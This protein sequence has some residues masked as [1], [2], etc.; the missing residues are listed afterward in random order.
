M[1]LEE[2]TDLG[3]L[4]RGEIV[5]DHVDLFAARLVDDKVSEGGDKLSGSVPRGGF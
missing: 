4:V 2:L 5:R 3:G 1:R